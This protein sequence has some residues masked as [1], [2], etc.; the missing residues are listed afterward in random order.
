[1]EE[2][3][4]SKM[5]PSSALDSVTWEEIDLAESYLVS[6]MFEEAAAL[7]SS[8]STRLCDYRHTYSED[9]ILWHNM[10]ESSV[11][12]L[13][14]AWRETGSACVQLSGGHPSR[15][16]DFLEDFLARWQFNN[17]KDHVSVRPNVRKNDVVLSAKRS[18]LE[19]DQYLKV[20]EFYATLLGMVLNDVDHALSWVEQA[21]LPEEARQDLLRRLV[22]LNSLKSS[23]SLGA[24]SV[25]MD[26]EPECHPLSLKEVKQSDKTM[27]VL[28]TQCHNSVVDTKHSIWISLQNMTQKTCHSVIASKGKI[29]IG[30]LIF[31]IC[32]FIRK[33]RETI[34]RVVLRRVLSMKQA[35]TDLWKLAFSYQVNPL[36]AVQPLPTSA[37]RSR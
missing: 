36:A 30:C 37:N 16:R 14:Q 20:V 11:M 2:V 26:E 5:T 18:T 8:I 22:S 32:Y 12:V 17:E 1:M 29:F 6:G 10:M 31:L 7:A 9:E 35:L 27:T 3:I 19:V 4:H 13:V 23:S 24:V 25:S 28:S 21:Q 33:K 34:K 15:V